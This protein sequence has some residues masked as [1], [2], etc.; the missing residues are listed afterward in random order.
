MKTLGI[1]PSINSTGVCLRSSPEGLPIYTLIPSKPTKKLLSISHP[2]LTV[3]PYAKESASSKSAP[4][5]DKELYKIHNILHICDIIHEILVETRPDRIIMEGISYGSTGSAAL[6]DLAGL[7]FC[8]RQ[9]I[10]RTLPDAGLVIASPMSVKMQAVGSGAATKDVMID[11]WKLVDPIAQELPGIK[12]DDLADAY[13]LASY[14]KD[15]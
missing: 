6:A 9:E 8:L 13:F 4:Y 15:L 7:N 12:I 10:L 3:A 11:G 14:D 5:S 2:R 1:D